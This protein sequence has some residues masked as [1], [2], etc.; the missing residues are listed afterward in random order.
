M[1]R[2]TRA[3]LV[4]PMVAAVAAGGYR[5]LHGDGPGWRAGGAREGRPAAPPDPWYRRV[6]DEFLGSADA[7][8]RDRAT[9][10]GVVA[11]REA[12][13]LA[14]LERRAWVEVSGPESEQL[15]GRPLG[16]ASGR[17]VLLRALAWD[18]PH[19]GFEVSWVAGGVRVNHGCLGRHPLPVVRRAV[20]ARLPEL[21]SEVYVDLCMAE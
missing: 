19:G 15:A 4:F 1:K 21:P 16:G 20:V 6:P 3:I 10:A 2:Q 7:T 11:A 13:S 17:L 14:R 8:G 12:E 9:F 5:V 18:T